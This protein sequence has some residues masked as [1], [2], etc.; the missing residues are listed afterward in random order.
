MNN[1][2]RAALKRAISAL[3]KAQEYAEEAKEIIE[4]VRDDEQDAY[5][6]L[7]AGIQDSERGEQME[8]NCDDL[9]GIAGE[10]DIIYDSCEEQIDAIQEVIDK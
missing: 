2:R 10:I 3:N 6:S 8:E 7:P 5:D 9:D 1:Q 4:Y